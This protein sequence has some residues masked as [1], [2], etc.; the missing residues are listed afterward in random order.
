MAY[1]SSHLRSVAEATNMAG[2]A[3]RACRSQ[4]GTIY[5]V[6]VPLLSPPMLCIGGMTVTTGEHHGRR[7]VD[8][9]CLRVAK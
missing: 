8:A 5:D 9:S 2:M 3:N 7:F 6:H 1:D 4:W